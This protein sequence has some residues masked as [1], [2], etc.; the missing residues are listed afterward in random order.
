MASIVYNSF[1]REL[2]NGDHDLDTDNINVALFTDSFVEDELNHS[3]FA[4]LTGEVAGTGYTAGGETL[5]N[6]S[7]TSGSGAVAI[8]DADNVTWGSST[9]TARYA[10]LYN[11]TL[12]NDNLICAIDFGS[13]QS[14]SN[15]NFTIQWSTS[16]IFRLDDLI[17]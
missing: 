15:G 8:F 13:N 3:E 6:S 9:I 16:G 5:A 2:F 1:K 4:D 14:S 11:D 7:I 12:A 10:V 17:V